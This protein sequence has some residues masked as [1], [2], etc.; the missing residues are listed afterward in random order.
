MR[1]SGSRVAA[2][3]SNKKYLRLINA[4]KVIHQVGLGR[5]AILAALA[6][7]LSVLAI[8][9]NSRAPSSAAQD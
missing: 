8:I 3:Q 1:Y 2:E 7:D 4:K 9:R 6:D 5:S